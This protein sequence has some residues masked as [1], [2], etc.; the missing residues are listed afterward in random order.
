MRLIELF[1]A[2]TDTAAEP[3]LTLPP[4][5]AAAPATPAA[6]TSRVG[7][8]AGKQAIDQAV[9]VVKAVRGDRRPQVVQYG[10]QQFDKL[11]SSHINPVELIYPNAVK[12][13]PPASA[14]KAVPSSSGSAAIGSMASQLGASSAAPAAAPAASTSSTGGTITPTP[15]GLV[16][17][18]SQRQ[19]D[20][21]A[22]AKRGISRMYEN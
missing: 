5:S 3:Y 2:A 22:A 11:A 18:R 7:A 8:P 1:E 9:S 15:T 20:V 21:Y 13:R 16:H 12:T 4:V 14:A 10:Q 17:N 19:R 6:K